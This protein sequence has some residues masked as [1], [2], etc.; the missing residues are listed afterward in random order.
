MRAVVRDWILAAAR[1]GPIRRLVLT[2]HLRRK[3]QRRALHPFDREMGI[4]A[5]G[6]VSPSLLFPHR[7]DADRPAG[8]L[9]CMPGTA[10]RIIECIPDPADW[11]FVDL[12]CGMGRALVVASGFPFRSVIGI[13]CNADLVRIARANAARIAKRFPNRVLIEVER[14][15]AARPPVRGATVLF[16]YHPFGPGVM[17][18][19]LDHVEASIRPEDRLLLVYLNPVCGGQVDARRS[20][21]RWRAEILAHDATDRVHSN[22]AGDAVVIWYVG[23][24]SPTAMRGADRRIVVEGAARAGLLD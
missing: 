20:F 13:E 16:M 8:Y 23:E 19:L 15:D 10:R 1:V 7:S 18:R 24:R 5:G 17:T 9:G 3:R 12:G 21:R 22:D 6:F 11:S 4:R 14:G 2:V